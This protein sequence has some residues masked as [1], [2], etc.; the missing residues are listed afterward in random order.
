MSKDTRTLQNTSV[1]EIAQIVRKNGLG[2]YHRELA[3][4][5]RE[6]PVCETKF[7]AKRAWQKFCCNKCRNVWAGYV[8]GIPPARLPTLKE[9][10]TKWEGMRS[11]VE[12]FE[13]VMRAAGWT[14][15]KGGPYRK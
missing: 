5:Q 9:L 1:E 13:A 15:P 12:K 6:C 2:K 7:A 4:P 14:G 8:R 3:R 11:E 10:E